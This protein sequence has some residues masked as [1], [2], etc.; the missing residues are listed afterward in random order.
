MRKKSDDDALDIVT[1]NELQ[2]RR[3]ISHAPMLTLV[4]RARDPVAAC[5]RDGRR[6]R[7]ERG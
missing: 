1:I 4:S 3:G 7:G 6:F 5:R 2:T